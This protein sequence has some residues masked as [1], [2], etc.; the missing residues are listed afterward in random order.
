[1]RA[2][3]GWLGAAALV[4]AVAAVCVAVMGAAPQGGNID[5]SVKALLTAHSQAM[6]SHN[7]NGV[8]ALWSSRP[9]IVVMGTGPNE[10]YSGKESVENAYKQFFTRYKA[11]SVKQDI[12]WMRSASRNDAGWFMAMTKVEATTDQGPRST[13]INWSGVLLKENG[14]WRLA[15][16][17]FSQLMSPEALAAEEAK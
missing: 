12:Y 14:K 10:A 1:M 3:M 8:M 11:G 17:H 2:K 6:S 4:V 5:S 15:A 7:L 9:D 16:V 13:G